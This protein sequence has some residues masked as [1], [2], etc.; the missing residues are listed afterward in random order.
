[1]EIINLKNLYSLQAGLDKEIADNHNV[2][3]ETTKTKRLLALI[4][5]IG[6]LAN[7]TRCFKFWS[8]KGPS[9]KEIIMD[10]FADGLHFLL[11]LGI[12]LGANKFDYELTKSD[13]EL[14]EQFLNVYKLALCLKDNFDLSH[15]EKCFSSYLNLALSIGM[16]CKDIIDSYN[17]KLSVNYQRQENNY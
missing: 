8:N 13:E 2:S 15:Y 3:Y 11:S 6:E 16:N 7:E 9:A 14:T 4:V 1:M 17:K 12:I 10:E 5:E